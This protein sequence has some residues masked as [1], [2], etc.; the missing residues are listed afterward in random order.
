MG[1]SALD[2]FFVWPDDEGSWALTGMARAVGPEEKFSE[3][4]RQTESSTVLL[5]SRNEEYGATDDLGT[6]PV[7]GRK[8]LLEACRRIK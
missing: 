3:P 6:W 7:M 4:E 5:V 8:T 1:L 2:A